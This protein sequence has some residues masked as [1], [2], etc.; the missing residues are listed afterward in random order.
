[1]EADQLDA[2]AVRVREVVSLDAPEA[3]GETPRLLSIPDPK[4]PNPRDQAARAERDRRLAEALGHLPPR[5][6][7]VLR[8]RFGLHGRAGASLKELGDELHLSPEC[9]RQIQC[10]ALAHLR[11]DPGCPRP[12]A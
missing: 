4:A 7:H 2:T 6:A 1:M 8:R 3:A 11:S 9:V 5:E 12:D 10:R